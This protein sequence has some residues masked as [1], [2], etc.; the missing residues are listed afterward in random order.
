MNKKNN[1]LQKKALVPL[2]EY[3]LII[4][5]WKEQ[6]EKKPN[7]P[8]IFI[9][10]IDENGQM[11]CISTIRKH[12]NRKLCAELASAALFAATGSKNYCFGSQLFTK[13]ALACGVLDPTSSKGEEITAIFEALQALK[14]EDEIE[15]MLISRLISMHYQYMKYLE[16]S[17]TTNQDA[18]IDV[19]IN[20]FAKLSRLYNETLDALIRYRRKGE[21]K[22]VVQHVNVN[23]GGRAVVSGKLSMGGDGV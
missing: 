22:V 7:N 10:S 21:Q 11:K 20:R 2:E 19:N 14:P 5:R 12:T 8:M 4:S 18:M 15:G 23:E 17:G 13:C 6:I 1:N 16:L 3:D 9:N